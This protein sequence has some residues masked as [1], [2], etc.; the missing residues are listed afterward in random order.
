VSLLPWYRLLESVVSYGDDHIG[1]MVRKQYGR[2]RQCGW[3][4][5]LWNQVDIR[6]GNGKEQMFLG[7]GKEGLGKSGPTE[8]G[9]KQTSRR[10]VEKRVIQSKRG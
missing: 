1:I 5:E 10:A 7:G 8:K 3:E 4:D 9:D 2:G 6:R